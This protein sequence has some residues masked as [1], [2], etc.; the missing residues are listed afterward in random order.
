MHDSAIA[1]FQG[2]LSVARFMTGNAS[3]PVGQRFYLYTCPHSE[4]NHHDYDTTTAVL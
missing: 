2:N 4:H 1:I 3:S